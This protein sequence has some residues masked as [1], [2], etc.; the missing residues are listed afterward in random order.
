MRPMIRGEDALNDD[1]QEPR[2]KQGAHL[3]NAP[4]GLRVRAAARAV[5]QRVA[6]RRGERQGGKGLG[7]AEGVRRERPARDLAAQR[8]R[9]FSVVLGVSAVGADVALA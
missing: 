8:E 5:R 7:V 2:E 6:R 3:R 9:G 1:D 4:R